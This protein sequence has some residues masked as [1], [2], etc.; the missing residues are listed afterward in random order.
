MAKDM[1]K[2]SSE[3]KRKMVD[4]CKLDGR[5]SNPQAELVEILKS[6]CPEVF[7]EGKVDV[8]RLKGILAEEAAENG[9]RY[10]LSWAGKS[11]YGST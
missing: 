1:A 3:V 8:E 10:G 4:A 2:R 11:D 7:T 6:R 5:S 9:E